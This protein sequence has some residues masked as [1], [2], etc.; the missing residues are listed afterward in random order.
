[1][2]GGT[3]GLGWTHDFAGPGQIL[4]WNEEIEAIQRPALRWRARGD[5]GSARTA[6]STDGDSP[7]VETVP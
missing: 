1:M 2:I 6:P 7:D 5:S 3:G 4:D